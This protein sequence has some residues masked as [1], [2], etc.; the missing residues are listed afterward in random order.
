MDFFTIAPQVDTG[1]QCGYE[2]RC[3]MKIELK[4]LLYKVRIVIRIQTFLKMED[5][6][7]HKLCSD[8][9]S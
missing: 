7:L 8:P 9:Q 1:S 2:K 5:S 4:F 6:D 3:L